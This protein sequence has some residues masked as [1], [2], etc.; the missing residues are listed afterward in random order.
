MLPFGASNALF[1][2]VL[3]MAASRLDAL[4]GERGSPG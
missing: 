2:V 4:A 3:G 1:A